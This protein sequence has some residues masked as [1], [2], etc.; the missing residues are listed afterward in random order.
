MRNRLA[1]AQLALF[2]V[3]TLACGYYVV[4][5]VAGPGAFA[6]PIRVTMRMPDTGGLTVASRVTYRGVDVGDVSA[7]RLAPGRD[8]VEVALALAPGTR[9]PADTTAVV[10]MATP[11][12][13]THLDLRPAGNGPPYLDSG[14]VLP[15]ERTRR[16][17]PLERL[18]TDFTALADSLP[19]DDVAAVGEALA[20]GLDGLGPELGRVLD[21]TGT[22]LELATERAPQLRRIIRDGRAL[23]GEDGGRLRELAGAM[24]RF[25]DAL[26][27]HDPAIR[28]LLHRVPEPTR[29]VAGLLTE[30]QPA[31]TTLLG[32]LVTTGQLVSVRAPAV[33]QLLISLPGTLT[34]LG[35]IVEGDTAK[36]YLVGTQGPVCYN[37][38]PRRTP[39]DTEPR[40][41][42]LSWH[43]PP[44]PR[45]SQ[46]GAANAPRPEAA[47]R[48]YDPGTGQAMPFDVGTNGG[49][50][51]VLGPRSWSALLLQG[52]R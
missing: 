50:S 2:V 44:G 23:L 46:R 38:T 7:V 35:G 31:L 25:T 36:F 4:T 6:T 18:L 47:P 1:L 45:L 52:A 3:I 42:G 16:P 37:E 12:A 21:N 22:L 41:P 32:N 48:T 33:E 27:E 11:M 5:S 8:G 13:I 28:Q 26:R 51:A 39:V 49:Q 30:N 19:A 15:A 14:D 17:L 24:R 34:E 9:V 10:T 40:E 20:T 29:R 43:C